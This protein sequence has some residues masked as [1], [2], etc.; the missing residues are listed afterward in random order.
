MTLAVD[1]REHIDLAG[2][3][4]LAFDP[5]GAGLAAGWARGS[6]PQA[7][8]HSIEVPA[9]WNVAFPGVEGVG[10]YRR[11]F[12]VPAEWAGRSIELQFGGASYRAEAWL[13]AC[14]LG[15]HEGAYTSFHFDATAAARPGAENELVVRVAGLSKSADV[16]GFALRHSPASKQSWYYTYSGLW[17]NVQL[18]ALPRLAIR[19]LAIEPDLRAEHV[20]IEAAVQNAGQATWPV[21]LQLQVC[22]ASGMAVAEQE[23]RVAP[24]PGLARFTFRIAL[25]RPVPWSCEHPHLYTL[26]ASLV[27]AGA[28]RDALTTTF[29]MRDFTV[30]QGQF[31]L[32]G[33]PIYLRGALLQPNYPVTLIAPP[34]REMMV[35]ELRLVKDAGFNLIRAHLRPAPTGYLDLADQMGLMVYAESPL[36]WIK[37]SPRLMDHA[38]REMSALIERDRNHP[39][40][41]F[42]GIYNENPSVTALTGAEMLRFVRG[43]D[44]TRVVVDDS[45]GTMAI[46]QDFGWVDRAGMVPNR[47]GEPEPVKDVHVYVGAPVT[48][49]VYEWLRTL[50]TAAPTADIVAEGY[51]FRPLLEELYR[52]FRSYQGKIF[53][54][55]L[56][57]G[58]MADLDAVVAGYGD[59]TDLVDAQEMLAFRDSLHVGFAGR[60]L[61]R[62]FGSVAGLIE[63]SQELQA[64]TVTRQLE[65]VLI[66]PRVS[67][68]VVTQL[69]DVAWEFHAGLLD[70]WRHP[71]AVYRAVQRLNRPYCLV[72]HARRPAVTAGTVVPVDLTVVATN[73]FAG[74]EQIQVR[75]MDPTARGHRH[76]HPPCPQGCRHPEPGAHRGANGCRPRELYGGGY[77]AASRRRVCEHLRACAGR[78]P[79]DGETMARGKR[80]AWSAGRRSSYRPGG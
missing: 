54:S 24:P 78:A 49:G 37:D 70:H 33:Q 10:F 15:S 26:R 43:L 35:R 31:Y 9:P 40:V 20:Q 36:A 41:V 60:H 12:G 57:Y 77:V 21:D 61:E 34:D 62:V 68:F 65:A 55:E 51:G 71:K 25:P 22:D 52:G 11:H 56:G 80:L 39:S 63:A 79:G 58:G 6:Y 8:A 38:R 47:A 28:E 50:G 5:D 7:Q 69:N 1:A 27:D 2:A 23:A 19:T 3:W 59:R 48:P 16:D 74:D 18:A 75:V 64:A 46:D 4:Q 76:T 44:P 66:N 13:N 73:P 29:G 67:G 14:Y 45:G 53:V 17:G 42:W 72:L 32:N 30:A